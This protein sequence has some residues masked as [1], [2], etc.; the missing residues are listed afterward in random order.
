MA[1]TSDKLKLRFSNSVLGQVYA[2]N[3]EVFNTDWPT[4]TIESG[5][6]YGKLN[7]DLAD[8][9]AGLQAQANAALV[10]A[11]KNHAALAAIGGQSKHDAALILLWWTFFQQASGKWAVSHPISGTFYNVELNNTPWGR[12]NAILDEVLPPPAWSWA[13]SPSAEALDVS[14]VAV[15]GA[16]LYHAYND[17]GGGEF[18][19][20][21][22]FYDAGGETLSPIPAGAYNVR[23]AAVA[24]GVIGVMGN[25]NAVIVEAVESAAVTSVWLPEALEELPSF[26]V[27]TSSNEPLTIEKT[28]ETLGLDETPAPAGL[29]AKLK[30][31]ILHLRAK[32]RP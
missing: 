16:E 29:R 19:L 1:I 27:S 18:A 12:I 3:Y 7:N 23:I 14:C 5:V 6:F 11:R 2:I 9:D 24:S 17:L 15:P 22:T 25:A 4:T 26:T 28:N 20:L 21:G 32:M 8:L 31:A 30:S 13:S 10:A